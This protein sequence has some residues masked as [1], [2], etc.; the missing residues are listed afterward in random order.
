MWHY[1]DVQSDHLEFLESSTGLP[2][3]TTRQKHS[4]NTRS[5]HVSQVK[6]K[7]C[8][9]FLYYVVVDLTWMSWQASGDLDEIGSLPPHHLSPQASLKI[10][11][12]EIKDHDDN[13]G[14][15]DNRRS[16][17]LH[18]KK[19]G[20][21]RSTDKWDYAFAEGSHCRVWYLVH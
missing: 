5:K 19:K 14:T 2:W 20:S 15:A 17:S 13:T 4:V 6:E 11:L 9:T 18:V 12:P 8:S 10:I 3:N 16:H 7:L 1:L 21:I